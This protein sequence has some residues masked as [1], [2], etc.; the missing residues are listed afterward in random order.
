ME[1]NGEGLHAINWISDEEVMINLSQVEVVRLMDNRHQFKFA[2]GYQ[3]SM[4]FDDKKEA[5]DCFEILRE[6]L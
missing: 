4:V 2:S 3:Y 1:I 6:M 5:T